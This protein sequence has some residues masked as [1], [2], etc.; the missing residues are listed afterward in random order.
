MNKYVKGESQVNP[1]L[2]VKG[3]MRGVSW[4]KVSLGLRPE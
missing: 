1:K 3:V 2:K 4:G